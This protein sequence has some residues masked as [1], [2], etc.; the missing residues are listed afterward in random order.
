MKPAFVF[1]SIVTITNRLSFSYE[2]LPHYPFLYP[3]AGKALALPVA[4]QVLCRE[5]S[6]RNEELLRHD[7][8]RLML[9][10]DIVV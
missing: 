4:W 8:I 10:I 2:P 7:S 1:F 9:H 5:K 6:H 3:E